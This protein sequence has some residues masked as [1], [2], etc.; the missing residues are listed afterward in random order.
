MEQGCRIAGCKEVPRMM[1]DSVE[2]LSWLDVHFAS[3]V[4]R[5]LPVWLSSCSWGVVHNSWDVEHVIEDPVNH[6]ST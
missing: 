3:L 1:E 4:T 6:V 2:C 5:G